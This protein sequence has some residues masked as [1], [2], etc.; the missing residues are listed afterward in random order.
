M[1]D[2][3]SSPFKKEA[4]MVKQKYIRKN[5]KGRFF[6]VNIKLNSS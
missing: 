2:M 4:K 3:L 1:K 5:M 6:V